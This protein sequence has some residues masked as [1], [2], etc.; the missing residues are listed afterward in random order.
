MSLVSTL[1]LTVLAITLPILVVFFMPVKANAVSVIQDVC[2]SQTNGEKASVCNAG[3]EDPL[4]G[5]GGLLLRTGSLLSVITGIAAI[6]IMVYGGYKF[7]IS[8][9]DSQKIGLAKSI[10]AYAFVGLIISVLSRGIIIFVINR[11]KN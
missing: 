10:I 1:K 9:G 11:I 5:T 2:D 3:D 4:T 6:I 8:S 7:V